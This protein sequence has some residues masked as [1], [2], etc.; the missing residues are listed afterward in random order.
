MKKLEFPTVLDKT[1]T[2]LLRLYIHVNLYQGLGNLSFIFVNLISIS[3]CRNL[4]NNPSKRLG[5]NLNYYQRL[6]K[7]MNFCLT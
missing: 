1:V 7:D 4:N 3:L 6:D 5:K 2:F